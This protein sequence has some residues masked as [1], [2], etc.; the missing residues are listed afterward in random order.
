MVLHNSSGS[1][2]PPSVLRRIST[3]HCHF[4]CTGEKR[5]CLS[6]PT[7]AV[8][9]S[10]HPW[11]CS[12]CFSDLAVHD[13][14]TVSEPFRIGFTCWSCHSSGK[15]LCGL[16]GAQ[17]QPLTTLFEATVYQTITL[18][19]SQGCITADS[20]AGPATQAS[21]IQQWPEAGCDERW[22]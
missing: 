12:S 5:G 2:V 21:C 16:P 18:T 6:L 8:G 17:Q 22:G 10:S 11:I 13:M 20:A 15:H 19:C 14:E 9:A 3:S 7:D 1:S 4:S